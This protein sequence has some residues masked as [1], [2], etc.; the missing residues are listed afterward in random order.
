MGHLDNLFQCLTSLT[1]KNFLLAPILMSPSFSLKP[2]SCFLSLHVLVQNL[3]SSPVAPLGTGRGSKFSSGPFLL[4][5]EQPKFS[6]P[7][8][9]GKVF[10]CELR[11]KKLTKDIGDKIICGHVSTYSFVFQLIVTGKIKDLWMVEAFIPQY[12]LLPTPLAT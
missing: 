5:T 8:F 10:L 7:V 2:F 3:S 11:N 6:Q 4:Q 9:T 12:Q 1:G